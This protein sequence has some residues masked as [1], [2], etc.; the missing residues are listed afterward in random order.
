MMK[1]FILILMIGC[2]ISLNAQESNKKHL[3]VKATWGI[4]AEANISNFFI[5]GTSV[6]DSKMKLGFTG[7][8]FLNLEFSEH[9]ALQGELIYHYKS[10]DFDREDLKGKYEYWGTEIP[11][12]AVYQWKLAKGN[13]LYAGIGPYTE[14]GFS[15]KLK[16]NGEKIDLYEKEKLAE[17]SAMK[18]SNVGF[19]VIVGYE[20][21]NG[22]QINGSYK[23]G[24]TNILDSNSN[25]VSLHP[26]TFSLGIGYRFK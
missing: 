1:K 19:G 25:S 3:D 16:R 2:C 14:F 20:F 8:A 4:K 15:A 6:I 5:S 11:I 18:D 21:A 26:N 22:I 13:R 9:F 24:I 10:S 17:V 12:Y 7:G 23:V